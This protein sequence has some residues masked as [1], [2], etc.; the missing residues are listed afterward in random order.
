MKEDKAAIA[1][2]REPRRQAERGAALGR[3]HHES[4][5]S[6]PRQILSP[7][8]VGRLC[9]TGHGHQERLQS[10]PHANRQQSGSH[11]PLARHCQPR[12]Q[13]LAAARHTAVCSLG[14]GIQINSFAIAGALPNA[15][16]TLIESHWT[17]IEHRQLVDNTYI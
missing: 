11:A 16:S 14:H 6:S 2:A 12:L 1:L 13:S 3:R 8:V 9:M 4:D 10:R 15:R 5:R 7:P 17:L